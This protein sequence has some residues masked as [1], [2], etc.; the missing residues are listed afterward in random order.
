MAKL[1]FYL[2][3]LIIFGQYYSLSAQFKKDQVLVNG[4]F[5]FFVDG[6]QIEPITNGRSEVFTF[7]YS[8]N[9]GVGKFINKH[10]A[11]MLGS[12][13]GRRRY[14]SISYTVLNDTLSNGTIN[15]VEGQIKYISYSRDLDFSIGLR[16]YFPIEKK[17]LALLYG[18]L[19]WSNRRARDVVDGYEGFDYSRNTFNI[20]IDPGV[21]YFLNK[22]VGLE[23]FIDGFSLSY[24]PKR[25]DSSGLLIGE[26]SGKGALNLGLVYFPK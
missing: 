2:L 20:D 13:F 19:N 18:R 1:R 22:K 5:R 3:L 4:G 9:A 14:Q 15:K 16:R 10:T 11:I 24:M 12:S 21:C 6:V 23:A 17:F 25:K 7:Y 26:F 8:I